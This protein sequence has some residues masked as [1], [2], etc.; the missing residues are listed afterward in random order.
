MWQSRLFPGKISTDALID[1]LKY[2]IM[3]SM[4]IKD[5]SYADGISIIINATNWKMTIASAK[6]WH[7][8][9][10]MLW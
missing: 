10:E 9:M 5:Q 2:I 8:L 1:G 6:Y 4:L 3:G 7:K